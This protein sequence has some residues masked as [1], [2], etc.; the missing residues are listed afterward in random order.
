MEDEEN[1]TSLQEFTEDISS[2]GNKP[3]LYKTE[4]RQ[5][6]RGVDCVRRQ[7][8]LLLSALLVSVSVN[9]ALGV[10][11]YN[12]SSSSCSQVVAGNTKPS[13]R[14][15]DTLQSHYSLL[16]QDYTELAKNCTQ[17]GV[18]VRQCKPCPDSWLQSE[19]RCY[20]FSPDKQTWQESKESCEAMG[21][22]LTILHSHTQHEALEKESRKL[23]GFDYHFWI[24]LSDTETEGVWKW[25]DNTMVNK[26]YW[27]EW[28]SEPDNNLSGGSH[29]QDCAVLNSRSRSWF[30]VPCSFVYNRICEMEAL[31]AN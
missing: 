2:K 6:V 10:L 9:I 20:Y 18:K 5:G 8:V 22:H 15:Y 17:H 25:V 7:P 3:I 27:D 31:E 26:T 14:R 30:D 19:G 29:G 28:D 21:S 1:Y 12:G 11:L 23:G 13:L 24:G 16:C 4:E